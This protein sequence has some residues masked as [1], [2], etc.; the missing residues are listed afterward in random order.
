MSSNSAFQPPSTIYY[1]F[2][3]IIVLLALLQAATSA[4]SQDVRDQYAQ[5]FGEIF[6]LGALR[7]ITDLVVKEFVGTW[8]E[9]MDEAYRMRVRATERVPNA[10]RGQVTRPQTQLGL[11]PGEPFATVYTNRTFRI[12]NSFSEDQPRP[13]RVNGL[14]IEL[15]SDASTDPDSFTSIYRFGQRFYVVSRE[16]GLIPLTHTKSGPKRAGGR[17]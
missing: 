14:R 8:Y 16:S 10:T 3:Y 6:A 17:E 9:D 12:H 5:S 7:P 4:L 13:L 11:K 2:R 15:S 1:I